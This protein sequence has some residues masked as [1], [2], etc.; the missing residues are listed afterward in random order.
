LDEDNS[1]MKEHSPINSKLGLVAAI[2]L[3]AGSYANA[4][5]TV[6]YS[7]GVATGISDLD[8]GGTTYNVSFEFGSYNSVFGATLPTFLG[9]LSGA[10]AAANAMMAVLNAEPSSPVIGDAGRIQGL[11]WTVYSVDATDFRATQLGYQPAPWQRFDNFLGGTSIDFTS[12]N[13]GFAK[14]TAV[15][16]PDAGSTLTLMGFGIAALGVMHRRYRIS[17]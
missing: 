13:W 10:G 6:N 16:A 5:S 4:V 7:S 8:V 11:L 14:F 1:R 15:A 9:D 3:F 12:R 17:A 2:F